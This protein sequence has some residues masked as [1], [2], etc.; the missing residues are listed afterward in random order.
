MKKE[1][2]NHCNGSRQRLRIED[3]AA[4]NSISN[5]FDVQKDQRF[6]KV[7]SSDGK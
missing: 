4:F 1:R 3:L 6:D 7:N 5:A 2:K